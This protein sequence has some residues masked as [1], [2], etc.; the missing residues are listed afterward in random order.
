MNKKLIYSLLTLSIMLGGCQTPSNSAS[1]NES[2]NSTPSTNDSTNSETSISGN[3][4]EVEDVSTLFETYESYEDYDYVCNYSCEAIQNRQ[5][6]GG[7]ETYYMIDGSDLLMRY[8]DST[9]AIYTDYYIYDAATDQMI[10]YLDMGNDVYQYLDYDNEF[11]FNYASYID[12]FELAGIEWE[13]DMVFDLE[14]NVAIPA[15]NAAKDRVGKTIFGDNANEYWHEVKVYW[16]E[17][18]IS[19]VEA[20]SIYQEVTY[21]YT[22]ELSDHTYV[23]GSI[24]VPANVEEFTNPYQPYLKGKEEYTGGA[25]SQAQID[26]LTIF[27]DE[28]SMNY[29][30]DVTWTYVVDGVLYEDYFLE[31]D[32]E[33]QN[34][35]YHYYYN[36]AESSLVTYHYYLLSTNAASYP[37]LF[38]D[39]NLDGSYN[40][41]T[42]GM[43]EYESYVSSIYLDRVLFYGLDAND[44]IYDET[45]GYITAKDAVT[46]D[47]YCTSI[48][49]FASSYGGLR[50]YLKD[51]GNGNLVLDKIVTSV[52]IADES[53]SA[54]SFLKT[55]TFSNIN[56]T[57]IEYPDGVSI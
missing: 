24:K 28:S 25:L 8:S 39:D 51:D 31:F 50:I 23:D 13:E 27:D 45:K 40:P 4:V 12:Y 18:F 14:N 33:A 32:L 30:V 37:V 57:T 52:Y 35:S 42:Y 53:G 49:Y 26:A 44:F 48:F 56:S 16:E 41:I 19:K 3:F 54:Y 34:G 38:E 9:G 6:I 1:S 5:Y 20:I 29:T 22:V 55:Y 10:Y 36:D 15:N 17:G 11:Y 2:T 7:W 21:Y 43:D 47:N 46:E